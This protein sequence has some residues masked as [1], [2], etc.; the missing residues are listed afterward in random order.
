MTFGVGDIPSKNL[1]F[2]VIVIVVTAGAL[3]VMYILS[4][5]N[6]S[7]FKPIVNVSETPTNVVDRVGSVNGTNLITVDLAGAVNKPGVYTLNEN[8]R[9]SDLIKQGGGFNSH[10]SA[11]WVSKNLNLAMRIRDSEKVYIPFEWDYAPDGVSD[12]SWTCEDMNYD[13]AIDYI[14]K[15][16]TQ[17]IKE[18]D[19]SEGLINVNTATLSELDTLPGIGAV[20]AQKIIDNRPYKDAAELISKAK[21]STTLVSKMEKLLK[22]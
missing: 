16:T 15:E 14:T 19:D 2:V 10:V 1:Y 9:I 20:Y 18:G 8:S 4:R 21:L 13:D 12:S 22:F 3:F 7:A 11:L 17:S 6:T 5:T